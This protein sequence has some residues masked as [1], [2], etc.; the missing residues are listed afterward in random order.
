MNCYNLKSFR[1]LNYRSL[2]NPRSLYTN[3]KLKRYSSMLCLKC[4]YGTH[5]L[6]CVYSN[7]PSRTSHNID[8]LIYKNCIRAEQ[9]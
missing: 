3:S 5:N 8:K 7:L 9:M 4:T 6:Q 2:E 1:F